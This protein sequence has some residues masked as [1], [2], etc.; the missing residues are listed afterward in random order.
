MSNHYFRLSDQMPK[1]IIQTANPLIATYTELLAAFAPLIQGDSK[2][3][4]E[5]KRELHDLWKLGAPLPNTVLATSKNYENMP[6]VILPMTLAKWVVKVSEERGM[7][8]TM[9]QALNI[10]NGQEDYGN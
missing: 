2:K 10:L 6:R 5:W 4:P 1:P 9:R 3:T 7:P 8:L